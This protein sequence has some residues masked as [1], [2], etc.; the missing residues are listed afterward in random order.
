MGI[1]RT[2]R[3][4]RRGNSQPVLLARTLARPFAHP[5]TFPSPLIAGRMGMR[6]RLK[7]AGPALDLEI[8]EN[9]VEI[10]GILRIFGVAEGGDGL[11]GYPLLRHL[12]S[13]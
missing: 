4:T 5:L 7:S 9:Q 6:A 10:N 8:H 3:E 1:V 12:T 13:K 2:I 11:A